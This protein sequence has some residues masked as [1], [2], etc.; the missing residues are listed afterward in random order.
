MFHFQIIFI[1]HLPLPQSHSTSLHHPT[2][3][4]SS[5]EQAALNVRFAN[6]SHRK[7]LGSFCS[8]GAIAGGESLNTRQLAEVKLKKK[9]D[10]NGV[11][12][13]ADQRTQG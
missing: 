5:G 6:N 9:N 4:Q 2:H 8:F 13:K 11:R 12:K 10:V 7:A 1:G 3:V